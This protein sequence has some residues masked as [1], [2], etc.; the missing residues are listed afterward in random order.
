MQKKHFIYVLLLALS[1]RP[2]YFLGVVA[3]YETHLNEIVE[4]YC[5]NKSTPELHCNG[6]CHLAKQFSAE[7]NQE[8]DAQTYL[9]E[10]CLAFIPLFFQEMKQI[11]LNTTDFCQKENNF[12][13]TNQYAYL[14]IHYIHKPPIV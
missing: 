3:Y 4:K 11:D 14:G 2:A 6:K 10:V 1:I 5:V 13:L 7:Q 8:T 12:F 9:S